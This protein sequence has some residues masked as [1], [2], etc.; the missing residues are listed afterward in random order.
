MSKVVISTRTVHHKDDTEALRYAGLMGHEFVSV[1][2]YKNSNRRRSV[3]SEVN[4]P[5]N[6]KANLSSRHVDPVIYRR[7]NNRWEL[8]EIVDVETESGE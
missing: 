1:A 8:Y 5:E 2:G 3:I 4:N 7:V 6:A